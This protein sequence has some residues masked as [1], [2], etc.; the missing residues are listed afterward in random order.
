MAGSPVQRGEAQ[1]EIR[2][3]APCSAAAQAVLTAYFRDI[4]GRHHRRAATDAEVAAAMRAEPSDDLCPPGGLLL[5]AW[6]DGTVLGCA[7]LRLLHGSAEHGG[8]G[9][10]TR[11]F[12]L[13]QARCRGIGQ[14]L[15]AAVEDAARGGQVTRLR[16]DTSDY[17]TEARRL[18]ARNGYQEVAPFSDAPLANLWFGKTL[19]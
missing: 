19:G 9:E 13:P 10:V 5:L 12:V 14:Q 4:V 16:L 6:Q 8:L 2:P 15:L 18:Y 7:G 3:E 17:L 1:L 11:M